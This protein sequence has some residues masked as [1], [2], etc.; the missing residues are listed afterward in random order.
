MVI[1]YVVTSHVF[2]HMIERATDPTVPVPRR[3][4]LTKLHFSVDG[5]DK[6]QVPASPSAPVTHSDVFQSEK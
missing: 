1:F 2:F 4:A 3:R 6:T 5:E